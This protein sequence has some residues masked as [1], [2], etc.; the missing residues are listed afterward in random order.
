MPRTSDSPLVKLL[1]Y[2]DELTDDQVVVALDV[3]KYRLS[4][5]KPTAAVPHKRRPRAVQAAPATEG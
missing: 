3:L 4:K 2:I 5:S 1:K